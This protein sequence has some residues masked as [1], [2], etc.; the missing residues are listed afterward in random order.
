MAHIK[1]C[2]LNAGFVARSNHICLEFI[3]L[4]GNCQPNLTCKFPIAIVDVWAELDKAIASI[5][6]WQIGDFIRLFCVC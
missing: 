3:S 2:V 5:I 4:T 1:L 6:G